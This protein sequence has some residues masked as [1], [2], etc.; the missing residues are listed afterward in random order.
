MV[1]EQKSRYIKV[2]ESGA[3]LAADA[4]AW[5]AVLDTQ[6]NLMWA[7]EVLP[8]MKFTAANKAPAKLAIA[9]FKDWRLPTAEELFCL[10]DRTRVDPAIDTDFFPNTPASWFWSSTVDASSPSG[11]AWVVNFGGGY[12]SWSL[13]YNEGFVR[14]VRPGQ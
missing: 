12:S 9:G 6:T 13:Q 2:G 4:T 10:A 7:V 5:A 1:S 3:L 14:A 11:C 8:R